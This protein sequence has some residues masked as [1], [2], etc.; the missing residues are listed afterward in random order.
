MLIGCSGLLFAGC[1]AGH[2]AG[3]GAPSAGILAAVPEPDATPRL[4]RAQLSDPAALPKSAVPVKPVVELPPASGI[5]PAGN[6]LLPVT[7]TVGAK[8]AAALIEASEVRVKVRAWVNGKPIFDDEMMQMVG[9]SVRDIAKMPEPQRTEK[10]HEMIQEATD[11]LIDQEVMYQD[12]VK[13]LEKGNPKAL[14]KLRQMVAQDYDKQVRKMRDAG[15]PEEY[16]R[17]TEHVTRRILERSSIAREYASSHIMGH[18]QQQVT[19]EVIQDYYE[20]HKNEFQTVDKVHWQDVFI[21]VGPKHPTLAETRRFA[22]D[23]IGKCRTPEDFAKLLG[24]DDG[25]SKFRGGEGFGQQRSEIRPPELAPHLFEMKEGQIGP[26]V[27]LQTGVHIFCLTKREYAGQ[28][29]LNDKVQREIRRKL[30]NQVAE[31]EYKELVRMLR[32]RSIIRIVRDG[33]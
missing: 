14:E 13:K 20:A 2:V 22:Q 27:D 4:A 12:A 28:L 30:E 3:V 10:L 8:Q 23:L 24:Y 11:H 6:P 32:A 18:I 5:T 29:P 31:R 9:P 15:V 25:D 7:G 19:L 17:A 26:V 1:T 21:A 16:I 33:P